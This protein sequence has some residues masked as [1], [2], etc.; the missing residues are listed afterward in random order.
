MS[1]ILI[2]NSR[3]WQKDRFISGH[4]LILS[5]GVIADLQPAAEVKKLPGDRR[6]DGRGAHALPGFV[7]LHMHGS[8]GFDVMDASLASL[9]GLSDFLVRHGV[10]SFLGT[11]M[12]AQ[13]ARIDAALRVMESFAAQPGTPFLGVHIEGPYLNPA[14]RGSQPEMHLREPQRE[15]Y[16]PWLES[17]QIKLIT[18]GAGACW[19]R[20]LDSG[21]A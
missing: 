19:W 15:E 13:A 1:R 8:K 4:T 16:L 11:T 5:D 10:T 3:I 12:T 18:I 17:G 7:D 6:L 9:Q 21:R 2:E 20:G 14:F